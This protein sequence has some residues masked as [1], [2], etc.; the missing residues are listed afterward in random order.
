M[1]PYYEHAG[2]TIYHGDAREVLAA[3]PP[4][5]VD[6]ALTDPPYS[7]GGFTRADRNMRP[8]TKYVGSDVQLERPD[9]SG[10]NRDQRSFLI[11]CDLWLR[12]C[13]RLATRTAVVASF[14]DWRQL[15]TMIDAVQVAGW[16]YRGLLV[17]DKTE[18]TR[19]TKGWFR[20]QAEFIVLGSAG[21]L[22]PSHDGICSPGVLRFGVRVAEKEHITGKPVDLCR[23][24][25]G[26]SPK[27]ECVLDP[28]MG[29]GTTLVAAKALGR[30]AIGIEIE[31]RYCE[32]AAKR[33]AQE[34]L[35]L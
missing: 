7:S 6:L 25:I 26:T 4:G 14:I 17:W 2:I 3:L 20:S 10:D 31:E 21:P 13:L 1:T 18:A 30:R 11:W 28:F 15:P 29:S 23:T 27:F 22:E 9:F 32:I 19:P 34:V 16:V 24:I 8:A 5:S 33:L 35:P 12:D